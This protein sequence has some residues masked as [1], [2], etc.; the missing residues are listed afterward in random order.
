MNLP[1]LIGLCNSSVL[2]R[3]LIISGPK[4]L[5]LFTPTVV[6]QSHLTCLCIQPTCRKVFTGLFNKA[7]PM[8][9]TV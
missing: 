9:S 8:S 7:V 3:L 5:M 1:Q 4:L 6:V 2:Q